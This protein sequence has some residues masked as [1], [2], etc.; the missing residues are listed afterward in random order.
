MDKKKIKKT[1]FPYRMISCGQPLAPALNIDVIANNV[2]K[3]GVLALL[4]SGAS[5]TL[6]PQNIIEEIQPSIIDAP[7]R[8]GFTGGE[9]ESFLYALEIGIPKVG[10]WYVE[11]VGYPGLNFILIGRDILN[12]W[13]LSLKG[14]SRVF[15]I[16]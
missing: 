1:P 2:E 8:F 12:K 3:K 14:R 10:T 11:A 15:E 13:S 4:D 16:S 5:V 6:I 7:I 9:A